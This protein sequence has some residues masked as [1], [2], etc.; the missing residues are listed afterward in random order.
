MN[1]GQIAE[2]IK[3]LSENIDHTEFLFSLL[4]CYGKPKASITRLKMEGKGSYNLSRTAGE[5]L[6]K[7]QV[8]FKKTVSNQLLSVIDEMKHSEAAARHQPRFII[9]INSSDLV[10]IDTKEEDT[11]DT[12]LAEL[13]KKFDFFLP[14]AGLEKTQAR[15]ENMADVKA[16]EKMAKLF[17]LLRESNPANT[18]QEIHWQN[19]FLS[20]I[21]FCFFAEDTGIFESKLFTNHIAS[22]T[23]IDGNDLGEYLG[24]VFDV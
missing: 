12:P 13:D 4:E 15:A 16:A 20:R 8:Y 2:K 10:A 24:L 17:D 11:L 6:W 19:V 7:K 23:A 3:V 5:I 18:A 1:I 14:W 9:A 22:H 21:L